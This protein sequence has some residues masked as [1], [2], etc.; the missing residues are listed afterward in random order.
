MINRNIII[1]KLRDHYQT[2]SEQFGIERIGLFGSMARGNATKESDIDLIVELNKPLG[3][4]FALLVE[5]LEA[6]FNK[7]VDV[8]T[9]DGLE[10]IRIKKVSDS[11]KKDIIYV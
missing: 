3:F 6:I 9:K 4:K 5:S 10:N 1:K 11:I 2:L 7:K 8:I